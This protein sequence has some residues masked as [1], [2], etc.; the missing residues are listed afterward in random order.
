MKP[1][2]SR[3]GRDANGT[4]Q[5]GSYESIQ[6]KTCM[7][8]LT[9]SYMYNTGYACTLVLRLTSSFT[10]VPVQHALRPPHGDLHCKGDLQHYLRRQR[11]RRWLSS[12]PRW[13]AWAPPTGCTPPPR[14]GQHTLDLQHTLQPPADRGKGPTR[15]LPQTP[16]PAPAS[17]PSTS[18]H[19]RCMHVHVPRRYMN[20]VVAARAAGRRA[21]AGRRDID[22]D[23]DSIGMRSPEWVCSRRRCADFAF[24]TDAE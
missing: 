23:T 3:F 16:A 1:R 14:T 11:A 8:R 2:D 4:Q 17:P 22:R 10:Y 6:P 20:R 19:H 13:L 12:P 7:T 18:M 24:A 9:R 21:A 5:N 15:S